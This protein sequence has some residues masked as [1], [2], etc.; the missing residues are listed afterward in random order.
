MLKRLALMFTLICAA[1][2]VFRG[3]TDTAT[4]FF[5]MSIFSYI[6]ILHERLGYIQT[7]LEKLSKN[8]TPKNDE[9]EA[10]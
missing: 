9:P 2:A 3:K 8:E 10:P 1:I 7:I 5:A 4:L 6:G